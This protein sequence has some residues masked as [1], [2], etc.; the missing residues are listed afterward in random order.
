MDLHSFCSKR[1]KASHVLS[2]FKISFPN[3]C[4]LFC[5]QAVSDM[6]GGG[7]GGGGVGGWLRLDPGILKKSYALFTKVI[8]AYEDA[9]SAALVR[10]RM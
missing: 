8:S 3:L 5:D 10:L 7:G 6:S 2:L 4:R 1:I 9:D